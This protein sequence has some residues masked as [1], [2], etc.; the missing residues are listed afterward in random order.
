MIF[1]LVKNLIIKLVVM[2]R[3]KWNVIILISIEDFWILEDN[4][5]IFVVSNN[6]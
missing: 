5:F 3:I 6:V 1:V 2:E 4:I